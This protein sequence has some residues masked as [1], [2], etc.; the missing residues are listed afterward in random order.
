MLAGVLGVLGL[1]QTSTS[2]PGFFIEILPKGASITIPQPATTIVP[3]GMQVFVGATDRGQAIKLTPMYKTKKKQLI[4][5]DLK[6]SRSGT[7][8]LSYDLR[9]S[10]PLVYSFDGL[11][12]VRVA[13]EYTGLGNHLDGRTYLKI[14]SN[15]PIEIS[16]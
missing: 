13:S 5:I 4:K 15:R 11:E 3:I 9:K 2:G 6:Q 10:R 1:A 12:T 8:Q 7:R 16:H 14:E